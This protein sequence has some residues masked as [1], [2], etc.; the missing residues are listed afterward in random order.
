[1]EKHETIKVE[2]IEQKT[3]GHKIERQSLMS[4]HIRIGRT[5]H[6]K[7]LENR[8]RK[9]IKIELKWE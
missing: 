2:T 4:T 5:L 6:S 1:M 9:T 8:R 7:G 3:A